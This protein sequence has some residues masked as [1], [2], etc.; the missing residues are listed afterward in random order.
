MTG[1][2][3]AFRPRLMLL[4]ILAGLLSFLELLA[5]LGTGAP[6]DNGS[7]ANGQ[8]KGIAGYAALAALIQ[9]DGGT[10]AFSR[11]GTPSRPDLVIVTPTFATDPANLAKLIDQRRAG[12]GPT[13]LVLPKWFTAPLPS[14]P[15]TPATTRDR[16]WA[17]IFGAPRA[18]QG[19][20]TVIGA[21]APNWHG[22][23]DSVT[24]AMGQAGGPAA[25]GW[26]SGDGAAGPL[27]DDH[28]VLSGQGADDAGHPLVPLIRSGDGRVLAGYFADGGRYPA[29]DR[30]AGVPPAD[31]DDDP[32]ADR[33][34]LVIVFEP[35]LL[36]NRGLA[37]QA[38]ALHALRLVQAAA[39]GRTPSVVFDLSQAGL[40]APRNLLT[41]AFTPP[42]LAATIC[43]V[44]AVAGSIWRGFVRFGPARSGAPAERVGKIA[45]VASGAALI[46]RARRLHLIAGPYADAAR[47]RL[48]VALGLPRRRGAAETDAAIER[49]QRTLAPH[50]PPFGAA[51]ARLGAARRPGPLA[52][53]ARELHAIERALVHD[54]RK[55]DS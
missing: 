21:G 17:R 44:L 42:F 35:D 43:L 46:L 23:L 14:D 2:P 22:V 32:D 3:S 39:G 54:R 51:A 38:T 19:W 24:V 18:P 7:G 12:R 48:Q 37:D 15:R 41:L 26:R 1:N 20:T 10:V 27:P 13:L 25:Q 33:Q 34:P 40:G 28:R 11:M 47:E 31:A 5:W 29:L 45:L 49:I 16:A 30:M 4:L 8:G 50:S 9:A 53:A 6:T 36:N 52:E 55:G